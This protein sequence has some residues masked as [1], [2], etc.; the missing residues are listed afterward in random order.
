MSSLGFESG[1]TLNY[2]LNVNKSVELYGM[3]IDKNLKLSR[4]KIEGKGIALKFLDESI[5]QT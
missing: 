5:H 3:R 4:R 1:S 2:N